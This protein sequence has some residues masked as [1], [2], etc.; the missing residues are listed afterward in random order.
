MILSAS[1]RTDLPAFYLDWLLRRLEEGWALVRNPRNPRQVSRIDLSPEVVDGIVFWS[2][3][4]APLLEQLDRLR[5]IPWY[6]QF[7]LN[8]YGLEIEPGIPPVQERVRLFRALARAAGPERVLWRYDPILISPRYPPE[9]HRRAFARL[10]E[11]LAGM[12]ECCTISFL[13]LYP[14]LARPLGELGIR[15]PSP[16]EREELAGW[17]AEAARENGITVMACAE[18]ADLS[19]YGISPARCVDAQ[20]LGRIGGVPLAGKKDPGQRPACG[21][22]GSIDLGLYHTCRHGCRYCYAA[23][24]PGGAAGRAP[25]DPASPLLCGQLLP[26]DRVT[27]R[28]V[29]SQRIRQTS[30]FP[31][32]GENGEKKT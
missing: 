4:P 14:G 7:T 31:P 27:R 12:T 15:P 21:C 26:E 29:Q 17:I 11:A 10:A 28:P 20:R 32:A 25:Y 22:D 16:G 1:R 3:N 9:W 6:L 2:K 19:G 30:L 8:A 5:E 18:E 13:D 23:V 24:M